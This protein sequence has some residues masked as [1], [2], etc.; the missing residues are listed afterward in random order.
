MSTRSP[1][2]ASL[3]LI[4]ML[5]AA[6]LGAG[7]FALP[8]AAQAAPPEVVV[9]FP[10][11][12]RN[13]T[14]AEQGSI[15]IEFGDDWIAG[16]HDVTAVLELDDAF[17]AWAGDG[18]CTGDNTLTCLAEGA[19]ASVLFAFGVL[20]EESADPGEYGY[21]VTVGVDGEDVAV[22]DGTFEVVAPPGTTDDWRPFLHGDVS[23]VDVT[24]GDIAEVRPAFLQELPVPDDAAAVA[25]VFRG[26]DEYRSNT[27]VKVVSGYDN[28]I[29]SSGENEI[30]V[31]CFVTDFPD[32]PGTVFRPTGPVSYTVAADAPGPFPFCACEYSVFAMHPEVFDTYGGEFW[33]AGSDNLFGLIEADSEG[34]FEGSSSGEVR[35]ETA[36]NPY[37][38]TVGGVN[39]E[40]AEGDQVPV[41]IPIGNEGPA[42]TYGVFLA[43]GSYAIFGQLPEGVELYRNETDT[44]NAGDWDCIVSGDD[45]WSDWEFYFPDVDLADLDFACF[46][47]RIEV[48]G[49]YSLKLHVNMIDP[50]ST[51]TGWVEI[52]ALQD[53]DYPGYIDADLSNNTAEL[54]VNGEGSEPLPRTGSPLSLVFGAAALALFAGI[55]LY[56]LTRRRKAGATAG[57]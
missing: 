50:E 19:E 31:T 36:E 28:C 16:E 40:G 32:S 12:L 21:T 41:T 51:D 3:P 39:I 47:D 53:G 48:G 42:G 49:E 2:K 26:V 43:P 46:F 18:V 44:G 5:G 20:A 9:D 35:I 37:D 45:Y 34:P 27:T 24:A 15:A 29:D 22:V 55:L 1:R 23:F 38:L 52:R 54:T 14:S 7:A 30:E 11:P 17:M 25:V 10:S 6:V 8:A 4:A 13:D 57:E 56:V 33:D